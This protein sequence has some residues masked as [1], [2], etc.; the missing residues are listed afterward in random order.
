LILIDYLS[1]HGKAF[2]L[3]GVL[4]SWSDGKRCEHKQLAYT[5]WPIRNAKIPRSFNT[6]ILQHSIYNNEKTRDP[7]ADV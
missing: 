6:P 4:E 5:H 2:K 7:E 1:R 3:L